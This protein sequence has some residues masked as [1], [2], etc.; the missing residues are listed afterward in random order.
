MTV[1]YWIRG[2]GLVIAGSTTPPSGAQAALVQK[3]SAIVVVSD[4]DTMALF[5]HN[6]N[7]DNS[8]AYF[9]EPEIIPPL[10]LASNGTLPTW[11]V[12]YL[13][14]NTIALYKAGG[15]GSGTGGTFIVNVR[16]PHAIGQ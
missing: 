6:W 14:N 13:S 8:A 7:L 16:R 2:G 1:T 4:T 15:A 11:T 9:N 5:T 12:G 10:A 3:Q